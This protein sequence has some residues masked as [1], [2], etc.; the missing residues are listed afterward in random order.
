MALRDDNILRLSDGRRLGYAEYGDAGGDPIFIFHGNP[1]SRL[2][3]GLLPGSSFRAGLR[4]IA[5]DRPGYGLSDFQPGRTF[6]DW[7]D[8]V[9]SLA[10]ALGLNRFAVVGVSGGGPYALACAW[11]IPERLTAV[12][13]ISAVGPLDAPRAT[14]GMSRTN[15]LIFFLARHAP[16][17]TRRNMKYLGPLVHRSPE[18]LIKRLI[19]DAMADVDKAVVVRREIRELFRRDFREAFRQGGW[20]SAHDVTLYARPWPIPLEQISMEVHLWQGE[21]D[22]S[23]PPTMGYYLARAMP[24]C[25]ATFIPNAGHLWII[26]HVNEVLATLVPRKRPEGRRDLTSHSLTR[27]A[28]RPASPPFPPP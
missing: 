24:N 28:K 12:G 21:A 6:V 15:R 25:R 1:G 10:N 17:L 3:W 18:K 14:E 7:P 19:F 23:V 13:V 9:V 11:K 5:P 20:G 26:D 4:V 2:S 27:L 22:P 8:D 16:R